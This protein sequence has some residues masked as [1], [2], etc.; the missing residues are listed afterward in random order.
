[1]RLT[2]ITLFIFVAGITAKSQD[3]N[4][5][6]KL[7]SGSHWGI[8]Y[9]KMLRRSS[10]IQ[11]SLQLKSNAYQF[12]ALRVFHE[13]AF[14]ATSSQWFLGYGYGTHLA[15]KTKIKSWNAFRPLAP[16]NSYKGHYFSPGFDGY[17]TLEYRFLKFPFVIALEYIPNF[18]FFGPNFY[19]VNLENFNFSFA[20]TF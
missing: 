17:A 12:T 5:A 3:Y 7:S 19:R 2:I 20:Y 18:E 8:T 11:A 4:N 9:K 15:Y 6:I 13:P 14:P 1:M 16:S 10:G